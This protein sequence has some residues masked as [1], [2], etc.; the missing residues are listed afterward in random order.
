[1]G[2]QQVVIVKNKNVMTLM[3]TLIFQTV[4]QL[5]MKSGHYIQIMIAQQRLLVNG[6]NPVSAQAAAF[7][8]D[9]LT[10]IQ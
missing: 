2:L 9:R 8:I 3:K 7:A 4:L 6:V 1:M 10:Q 5:L